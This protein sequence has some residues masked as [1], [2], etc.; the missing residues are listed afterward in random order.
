MTHDLVIIGGGPAGSAA[1]YRAAKRGAKVLVLEKRA[2]PRPK[3]C[4]GW[5]S[6]YALGLLPFA[7]PPEIIEAPFRSMEI[8]DGESTLIHSPQEPLGIFVDR[9][10]FDQFLLEQAQEAGAE[11]RWEKALAIQTQSAGLRVKTR[12]AEYDTSG[13]IIATGAAGDLIKTVRPPDTAHESAACLEQRVPA[14]YAEQLNISRGEGRFFIGAVPH[15]F[16]W[17][18]HHGAYLLVGVGQRRDSDSALV[19]N[20][21]GLWDRL[22]LPTTLIGPI[23]PTGHIIPFGGHPRQIARGRCLLAGDAAGMVDAQSGEG[24]AGAIESGQLA[25]EALTRDSS[26]DV[27]RTYCELCEL[28]LLPHLRW[29]RRFAWGFY[30]NPRRALSVLA[31]FPDALER[32]TA[33]VDHRDS[34]PRYMLWLLGQCLLRS[35]SRDRSTSHRA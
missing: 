35:I 17:V 8:T 6:R 20:F 33:V 27:S 12:E 3:L 10:T 9:A 16:G 18:L 4:G 34:Y 15:G 14:E 11:V 21:L 2:M 24:I 5:V 1:A 29:S 7:I 23:R 32:Y 25:A 31:S 30:R 22:A 19:P 13:V 28:S 26:P